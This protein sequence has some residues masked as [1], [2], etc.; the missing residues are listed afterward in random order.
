MDRRF[1]LNWTDIVYEAKQRRLNQKLTQE[2]LAKLAGVSTPTLSRFENNKKDIQLSSVLKILDMLGLSDKRQLQFPSKEVHYLP[3]REMFMFSGETE[4]KKIR[5]TIS[6]EALCDHYNANRDDRNRLEIF[7]A[8]R[9]NIEHEARR[10]Y[11]ANKLEGD[12]SILICT[13]DF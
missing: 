9:S 8:N 11:F 4:D 7:K 13:D 3:D 12:G 2:E 5:C 6:Y 1:R 10:K